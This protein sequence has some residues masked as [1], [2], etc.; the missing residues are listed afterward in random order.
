MRDYTNG[1]P[2][3]SM[4]MPATLLLGV[5]ALAVTAAVTSRRTHAVAGALG[6]A[7][8]AAT[9]PW[10]AVLLGSA[11]PVPAE[12]AATVVA[13]ALL[14]AAGGLLGERLGAALRLLVA[15]PAREV[16]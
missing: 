9:Y 11:A 4:F 5:A 7:A 2:R 15:S 6:G 3:M 16:V 13:G 14:G 8:L 1:L 10:Q 12:V